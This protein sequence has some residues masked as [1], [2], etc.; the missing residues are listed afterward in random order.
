MLIPAAAGS[1]GNFAGLVAAA[2]VIIM[3]Y[4]EFRLQKSLVD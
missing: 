1:I 2:A 3:V 4:G